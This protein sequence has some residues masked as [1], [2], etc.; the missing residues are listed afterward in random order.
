MHSAEKVI[1]MYVYFKSAE[2]I[3]CLLSFAESLH[4][5]STEYLHVKKQDKMT[6]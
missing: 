6:L 2:L 3:A 1:C 4:R 5:V